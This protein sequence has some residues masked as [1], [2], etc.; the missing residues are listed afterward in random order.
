[1]QGYRYCAHGSVHTKKRWT[2]HV[3]QSMLIGKPLLSNSLL[4]NSLTEYL[5]DQETEFINFSDNSVLLIVENGSFQDANG[6][7][8]DTN[9]WNKSAVI[10][11]QASVKAK[12][13]RDSSNILKK[14]FGKITSFIP[15]GSDYQEYKSDTFSNS[16]AVII[17]QT[18]GKSAGKQWCT[19]KNKFVA[20]HSDSPFMWSATPVHRSIELPPLPPNLNPEYVC[21]LN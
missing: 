2:T 13:L 4:S 10:L 7:Y 19:E 9:G 12:E 17:F 11:P 1:M 15:N 3:S 14:G 18:Q 5:V 8:Q 21:S 16:Y 20:A 6:A